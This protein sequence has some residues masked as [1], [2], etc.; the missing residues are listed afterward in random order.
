M[1]EGAKETAKE[2]ATITVKVTQTAHDNIRLL[3]ARLRMRNAEAVAY[4]V[5]K[6]L[7]A[8]DELTK[9]GGPGS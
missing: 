2:K 5:L 8:L 1:S 3:A 4:A 7:E 6:A 9:G